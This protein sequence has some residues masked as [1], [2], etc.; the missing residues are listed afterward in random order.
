MVIV[1]GAFVAAGSYPLIR[2]RNYPGVLGRSFTKAGT[3]KLETAPPK[4]WRALG[5][6]VVVSGLFYSSLFI[7][8]ITESWP[9]LVLEGALLLAS[10]ITLVRWAMIART[11]GLLR[12]QSPGSAR[13]GR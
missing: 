6:W 2:G 4:Y 10:I 9:M 7:F 13:A 3:R 11:H 5:A 1:G 8:L 12:W